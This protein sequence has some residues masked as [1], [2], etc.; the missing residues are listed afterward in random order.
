MPPPYPGRKLESG[1]LSPAS[2]PREMGTVGRQVRER[3]WAAAWQKEPAAG[4]GTSSGAGWKTPSPQPTQPAGWNHPNHNLK[5]QK[6]ST[7][8]F[9]NT[10]S[11]RQTYKLAKVK[12]FAYRAVCNLSNAMYEGKNNK[13]DNLSISLTNSFIFTTPCDAN[14]LDY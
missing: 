7:K 5:C 8:R 11:H 6:K 10:S 14:T 4:L 13:W 1:E 3:K 9:F 12:L 2:K